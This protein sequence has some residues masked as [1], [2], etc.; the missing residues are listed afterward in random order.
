VLVRPVTATPAP[1]WLGGR[2]QGLALDGVA[3]DGVFD[4]A[5]ETQ[6]TLQTIDGAYEVRAVGDAQPLGT[7]PLSVVAPAIRAA[8]TMFAQGNAFE[9]WTTSRQV[10]ALDTTTC[11]GD[12]LPV[13]GPVE[14]DTFVPALSFSG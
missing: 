3:P 2:S 14:L 4:L 12:R 9:R 5:S 1:P 8:L 6:R 10:A 7:I 13:P 11:R